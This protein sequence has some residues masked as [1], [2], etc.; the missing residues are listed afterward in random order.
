MGYKDWVKSESNRLK[1]DGCTGVSEWNH[2]CCLEHDLAYRTGKDPLEA[3]VIGW[4][5]AQP[6]SYAEADYRFWQCNRKASPSFWGRLRA[7]VRYAGVR[8]YSV[9]FRRD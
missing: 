1:A 8:I 9:F 2:F 6:I 4:D 3:Y 7:D 5:A